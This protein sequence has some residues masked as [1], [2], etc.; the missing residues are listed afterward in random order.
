M[1]TQLW[2]KY[3]PVIRILLKKT[4]SGEQVLDLNRIDFERAGSRKAG[5]KFSIEFNKGKVSNVISGVPLA[6]EF[7]NALL[8]DAGIRNVLQS[9]SYIISLNTKFQLTLKNTTPKEE[10]TIQ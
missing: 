10:E 2:N 8:E 9:G 7:A 5:Y 4:A 3:L 6:S 1:Y